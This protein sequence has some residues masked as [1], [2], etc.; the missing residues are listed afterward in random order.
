VSLP[1]VR[2]LQGPSVAELAAEIDPQLR[3]APV[4]S[5]SEAELLSRVDELSD[6]E[7]DAALG[8]LLD[9]GMI[10]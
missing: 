9:E 4:A 5:L 10:F 2:L 6:A 7:L 3:A 8:S 1:T